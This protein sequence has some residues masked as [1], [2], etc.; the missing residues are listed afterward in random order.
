[1]G[2]EFMGKVGPAWAIPYGRRLYCFRD[3][4]EKALVPYERVFDFRM[5]RKSFAAAQGSSRDVQNKRRLYVLWG[6]GSA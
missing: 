5:T 1:M 4:L 3:S 2:L 6:G